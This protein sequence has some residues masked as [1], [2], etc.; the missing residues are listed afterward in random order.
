MFALFYR[1]ARAK[2]DAALIDLR[3]LKG[4][5]FS[6]SIGAMFMVNGISLRG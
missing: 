3:L 4:R 5:V 2:G 6:A 1:T